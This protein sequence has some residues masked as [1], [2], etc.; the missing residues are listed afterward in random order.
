MPCGM[1]ILQVIHDDHE[2]LERRKDEPKSLAL[3]QSAS[4]PHSEVTV[5]TIPTRTDFSS[6]SIVFDWGYIVRMTVVVC[7]IEID[8]LHDGNQLFRPGPMMGIN[9]YSLSHL[10][11]TK[12]RKI[13]CKYLKATATRH[14]QLATPQHINNTHN[15]EY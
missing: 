2:F 7:D 5:G 14:L 9:I 15:V 6:N 13:P 4:S 3:M 1:L 11:L 12:N 10:I 8:W